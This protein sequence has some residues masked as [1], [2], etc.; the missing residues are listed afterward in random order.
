ME[1]HSKQTSTL[2]FLFAIF[3][4]LA[5]FLGSWL[6]KIYLQQTEYSKEQTVAAIECGRFYFHIVDNTVSYDNGTLHFE[7]ENTIGEPIRELTIESALE[8][9]TLNVSGLIPG[10]MV[11]ISTDIRITDWVHVYPRYCRGLNWK[12][13][14]FLPNTS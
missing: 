14:S 5:F 3:V 11:P 13:L 2:I 10:A 12:N 4:L 7:V 8:T 9:R 6:Y 1:A